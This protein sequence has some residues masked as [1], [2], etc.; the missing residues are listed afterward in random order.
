MS[1]NDV[2]FLCCDAKLYYDFGQ[3][4]RV[5]HRQDPDSSMG[6]SEPGALGSLDPEGHNLGTPRIV[7]RARSSR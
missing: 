4:K 2:T 1:N 3:S 5:A 7:Q 6:R